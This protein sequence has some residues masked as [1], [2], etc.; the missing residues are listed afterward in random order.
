MRLCRLILV[1]LLLAGGA[2]T[3]P[4]EVDEVPGVLEGKVTIGPICPVEREG[5]PCPTPPEAYA[6]RRILVFDARKSRVIERILID[7]QG[8]Y[9]VSLK[10]DQYV[11]DIDHIGID[12]SSDVPRTIRVSSGATVTLNIDIDT[13]IR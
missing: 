7:S 10:P 6:A 9:R 8:Q 11:I 5:Q 1:G 12:S 3:S 2:C 13:G 4:T